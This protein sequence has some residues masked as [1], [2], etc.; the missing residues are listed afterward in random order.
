MT[1]FHTI[2]FPYSKYFPNF[3]DFNIMLKTANTGRRDVHSIIENI[4]GTLEKKNT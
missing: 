2:K 3:I 4:K 1:Y